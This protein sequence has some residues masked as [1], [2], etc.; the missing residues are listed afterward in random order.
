MI[1]DYSKQKE[2][3]SLTHVDTGAHN[4]IFMDMMKWSLIQTYN[5]DHC[6]RR[7]NFDNINTEAYR[8]YQI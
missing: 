5:F 8:A 6:Y 1:N 7:N 2:R 4:Y 3:T